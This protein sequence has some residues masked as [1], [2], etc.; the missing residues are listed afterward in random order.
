MKKES[1]ELFKSA[2]INKITK[3]V[4]EELEQRNEQAFWGEK[5]VPFTEAILSVLLPLRDSNRLY[6]PEGANVDELTPELFLRW[7]DFVSLKSLAFRIQK[8][9]DLDNDM[10]TDIDLKILGDYLGRYNINLEEEE[11]DFPI[12][13]YNLHQGVSNVIKS[14]L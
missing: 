7:S 12:S 2:D 10:K 11:L 5:V 13:H 6:D 1:Y 9:N 8:S 4:S 3:V 14:L